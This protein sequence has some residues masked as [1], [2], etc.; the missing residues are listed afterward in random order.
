MQGEE[1]PVHVNSAT[2]CLGVRQNSMRRGP[3]RGFRSFFRDP[4]GSVRKGGGVLR[5]TGRGVRFWHVPARFQ[6]AAKY[7]FYMVFVTFGGSGR[8]QTAPK[9][10]FYIVFVTFGVWG[11]GPK[12]GCVRG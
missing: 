7:Q 8:L 5:Q 12:V 11:A 10:Q 2:E 9:C 4:Y 1:C 3:P 6:A